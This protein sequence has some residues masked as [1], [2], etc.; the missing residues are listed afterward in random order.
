M[1]NNSRENICVK[2]SG[3]QKHLRRRLPTTILTNIFPKMEHLRTAASANASRAEA[4][5]EL[6]RSSHHRCFIKIVVLNNFAKFTEK[7]LPVPE[8]FFYNFIKKQTLAEACNFIKKETL[9]QVFSCE[10]CKHFG[11]TFLTE[12]LWEA[13][14]DSIKRVLWSF[15]RNQLTAFRLLDI[16]VTKTS[17]FLCP[18]S[19]QSCN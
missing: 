19:F 11:N 1:M 2:V 5:L 3:L 4:H 12:Q 8:T 18:F 17:R 14:S 6:R 10:F 15:L 16:T 13:T 7:H 9:A